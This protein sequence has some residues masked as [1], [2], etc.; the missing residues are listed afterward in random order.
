MKKCAIVYTDK[1]TG[2]EYWSRSVDERGCTYCLCKRL[3]DIPTH[4]EAT[5]FYGTNRLRNASR[6]I[7]NDTKRNAWCGYSARIVEY[8][9]EPQWFFEIQ[10]VLSHQ[11][12]D[13]WYQP[14]R[15]RFPLRDDIDYEI[16]GNNK[17]P[18]IGDLT[19]E[20]LERYYAWRKAHYKGKRQ[21]DV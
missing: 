8:E 3:S 2:V 19:L 4:A 11:F 1:I 9:S 7:E 18:M 12:G 16:R 13:K 20:E 14:V 21:I 10:Y 17:R 5:E 6:Q 15:S